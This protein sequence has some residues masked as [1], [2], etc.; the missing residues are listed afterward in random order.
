M[1]VGTA[2]VEIR[3]D[4][5][6]FGPEMSR[7]VQRGIA[8]VDRQLR[9]SFRGMA[10]GLGG[11]IAG[12]GLVQFFRGA[13][14]EAAEAERVIAQTNAVIESTG[15]VAGISADHVADLA[16]ELSELAAVDDEIIQQGANLLLTF[17]NIRGEETFDAT[18]QA[19]L[20]LSAAM[21]TDLQGAVIQVGKAMNDPLRGLQG[22]GRAGIQFSDSQ[23]EAIEQMMAF[24]NVSGAQEIILQE[25]QDQ[26]GGA[27][28]AN[29][30]SADEMTVAWD[31]MK[32]SVGQSLIPVLEDLAP[33]LKGAV[34]GF[35]ALPTPIQTTTVAVFGLS[36]ALSV[37][38]S[39][40]I[41]SGLATA[42][43]YLAAIAL[44]PIGI[45]VIG[46]LSTLA[47]MY[48]VFR[49]TEPLR[50]AFVNAFN[51]ARDGLNRIIEVA[52]EALN[53]LKSL[54]GLAL[55]TL[56]G[57]L[58]RVVGFISRIP[59]IG[60]AAAKV[61]GN[62]GG[63][64]L[65]GLKGA[66]GTIVSLLERAVG[67][68]HSLRDALQSAIG[69]SASAANI[70]KSFGGKR[71]AGGPVTGGQS[72]LVGELGPEIFTPGVSGGIIP[73]HAIGGGSFEAHLY[74]DG[75]EVSYTT[76]QHSRRDDTARFRA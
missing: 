16:S 72:Y 17:K 21:G 13:I 25:L 22:L 32:E 71:A 47:I 12:V 5:S 40:G 29:K 52:P 62:L 7:G 15:G 61:I 63:I 55:S 73:N 30:T 51:A 9:S 68:A 64:A 59:G 46:L 58:D 11:I 31:N 56:K 43:K 4:A 69:A 33:V 18:L 6:G 3:P 35:A 10:R 74:L 19:A 37:L 24:G 26:F 57:A 48:G 60:D 67:L 76:D 38:S 44:S 1:N 27:A 2:F 42:A 53:L 8:P 65:S 20:D 70:P 36:I 23:K 14:D 34:D 49:L 45:L 54:G 41:L 28:E 66:L 50:T 75:R 39:S